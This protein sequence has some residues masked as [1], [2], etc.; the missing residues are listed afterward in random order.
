MHFHETTAAELEAVLQVHK[1]AFGR[2]DEAM[3]VESLMR[4]R[5]AQP[6]LSLCA[7]QNGRLA[8]H[9]LFTA[10]SLVGT[11]AGTGCSL[12]AP[13]AVLPQDQKA[14]VGRGLMEHGCQLLSG[15][16]IDLVFVL[17]D[18]AYYTRCGFVA[19]VPHGLHAPYTITP[20]EAWMVRPLKP[21]VLG[22][23]RGAVRCAQALA[24]EHY[25]R[26]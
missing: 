26:E 15:R 21:G 24:A 6:S 16:G 14:G 4:D 3:L 13:L 5:S 10:L 17:G 7:E 25:W 8:G 22:S 18:P 2:D 23:V 12:L 11:G 19:A 9:A 1:L 20:E